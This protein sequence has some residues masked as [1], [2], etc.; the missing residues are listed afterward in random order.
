[1]LIEQLIRTPK[2]NLYEKGACELC[3]NIHNST[4]M[5]QSNYYNCE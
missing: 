1:M 3:L 4:S 2:I 5:G